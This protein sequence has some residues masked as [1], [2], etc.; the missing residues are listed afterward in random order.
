MSDVLLF[1]KNLDFLM[2]KQGLNANGLQDKSGI[3][4]TTTSRI[5]NG[6]TKNPRDSVVQQYSDFFGVPMADLRYTDLEKQ[7]KK[8]NHEPQLDEQDAIDM[9]FWDSETPLYDDEFE[10]PFYKDTEF[11]GGSGFDS[12]VH[13]EGRR[14]IR[15]AYTAARRAGATPSKVVC[16]TL[17][18]DSMEELILDG[19]MIA[20]DTSK[21]DVREGKIYAFRHGNMLRVK[22]LIPRP[23]GGLIIRSHNPKYKDEIITGDEIDSENIQVLGWVWNW[24]SLMVW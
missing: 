2:K 1:A 18:G 23:D 15:Y 8:P 19:S 11:L 10:V 13:D 17:R 3:T 7:K 16:M 20:I 12:D 21:T 5:L 9:E 4:Q 22:Y 6:S 24:S 14:K